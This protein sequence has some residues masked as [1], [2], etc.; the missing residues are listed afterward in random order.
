M[1]NSYIQLCNGGL[2]TKRLHDQVLHAVEKVASRLD[3]EKLYK[4]K[5]LLGKKEWKKLSITER[6][7]AE[8]CLVEFALNQNVLLGYVGSNC[9]D[10]AL[11]KP[12]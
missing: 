2:A 8:N 11:F 4:L 12:V 7:V 6:C 9:S 5:D 3:C 10:F 1:K